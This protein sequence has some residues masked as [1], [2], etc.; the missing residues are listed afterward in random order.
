ME[1]LLSQFKDHL[2]IERRHSPNTVAGYL[3][4][5]GRFA[6]A[7]SGRAP[8]DISARE[9][10][11]FLLKE[12][13]RGQS[14]ASVARSLSSIKSFFRF[15]VEESQAEHNP[16]EILETPRSWRKLPEVLSPVDVERLL[17]TPDPSDAR[18]LRDRAM[19]EILYATGVRVSELVA[20]KVS[21]VDLTVGCLRSFGKG[22]K[23]RVVPLGQVALDAV[24][25][26]LLQGRPRLMKQK[27]VQHLFVTRLGAGMTRQGFWKT[28]KGYV[29]RAGIKG[30]VS[31][32]TLRHAFATHLLE[33]GADLRVVQEMLGHSDISTTQIYTHILAG[34]MREI[35][36]RFHP[37]AT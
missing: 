3:R 10:R 5:L 7:F 18:G 8:G 9:I 14:T 12:R 28:L 20:L 6:A 25:E 1:A 21:D 23:E 11:T 37:R 33:N 36:A 4:D 22:S 17:E 26:Y 35:H 32:H 15:L 31:P 19:L 27:A 2:S 34:R 16:A 30:T 13:E 24:T 29:I